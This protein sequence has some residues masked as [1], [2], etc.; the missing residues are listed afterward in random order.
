MLLSSVITYGADTLLLNK[1]E[2][3]ETDYFGKKNSTKF[4]R[5]VKD[6][7]IGKRRT[8]SNETEG[9]FLKQNILDLIQNR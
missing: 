8:R 6:E 1:V 3:N 4:F 7:R 9:L 5:P 2:E